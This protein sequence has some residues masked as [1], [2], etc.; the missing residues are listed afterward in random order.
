MTADFQFPRISELLDSL[1]IRL[2]KYK[3]QHFLHNHAQA[4]RIAELCEMTPRHRSVEIGAGLGNLS[5]E[6]ARRAGAVVS[7]EMDEHF[8]QWHATLAEHFP[9]LQFHY[10]DFL[11]TNLEQIVPA[12]PRGPLV[13]VGNLPYQITA[14]ILFKLLNS[15]ITW[16]RIVVMVQLEVAER[17]AAGPRERRSSALT[18]KLAFEYESRIAMKLGPREFLPPPRVQSAVVV[19]RPRKDSLVR[20]AEHK[21]RLHELVGGVFQHRRRTLGNAMQL[22]R[23]TASRRE[24][25]AAILRAG[26]DPQQ[27]PETLSLEDY[28][29]LDDALRE[30]G[31]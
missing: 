6:L 28:L 8:R 29:G 27:R 11:K 26:L 18:Y 4:V 14:P 16:E 21:R 10:G 9:N 23:I 15:K 1:G 24:A 22:G 19:L 2:A 3:S 31:K 20:D 5:V 7:V 13:A 25:D 12:Q 30:M 17:I